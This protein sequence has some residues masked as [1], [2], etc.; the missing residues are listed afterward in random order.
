MIMTSMQKK[1][2]ATNVASIN[3]ILVWRILLSSFMVYSK[4][5]EK[6]NRLNFK[7]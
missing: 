4:K 6:F 2:N 5:L 3:T 7:K 1:I